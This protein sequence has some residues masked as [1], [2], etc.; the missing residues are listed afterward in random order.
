ML[1]LILLKVAFVCFAL[2]AASAKFKVNL[3]ALGLAA[4]VLV[5]LAPLI[6]L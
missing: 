2:A 5:Y 1:T 3:I 6:K 4:W